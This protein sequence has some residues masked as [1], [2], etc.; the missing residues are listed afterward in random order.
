M[1]RITCRKLR[2]E[3]RAELGVRGLSGL[4]RPLRAVL[5]RPEPPSRAD[6]SASSVSDHA[7][8]YATSS[9]VLV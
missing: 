4:A 9:S 1:T 3:S 2:L 6:R 8:V 5:R 7:F